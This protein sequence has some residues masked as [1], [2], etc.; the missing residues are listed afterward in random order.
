MHRRV[1]LAIAALLAIATTAMAAPDVRG[2]ADVPWVGRYEGSH[3]IL[4]QDVAFDAG[5][6]LTRS[7][8]SGS[9]RN[10]ADLT[11][12]EG[13]RT[14][15]VYEAPAGRS[16]LEILRN[17]QQRLESAGFE[18]L[19]A[20][21]VDECKPSAGQ[22]VTLAFGRDINGSLSFS[23]GYF[24][25][26]RYAVYRLKTPEADRMV[27]IY[28]G[29][30]PMS[31]ARVVVQAAES[32][33]MDTDKVVV[34][35]AA[36]LWDKISTTG[37]VAL[38]GIYFDTGDAT[39]KAESMPTIKQIVKLMKSDPALSLVVV[40]HTDSQG[41]FTANVRCSERR[42]LAVVSALVKQGQF[43]PAR[44]TAFGAGMSAPAAPNTDDEGRARN[45]RVEL[46]QR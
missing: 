32:A 6:F 30:S 46:V 37:R 9:A 35:S 10:P 2:S 4:F 40:G 8:S 15:I 41:D 5:E 43:A 13:R 12:L 22:L 26:P 45:R 28:A 23:A 17:F 16:S 18:P 31:G 14:R 24:R 7:P 44:L 11:I 36:E 27:A 25:A 19:Y 21:E 20:C 34:P 38:Y 39:I 33:A 1:L 29:E 3:I 42:A